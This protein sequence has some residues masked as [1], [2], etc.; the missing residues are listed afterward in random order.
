MRTRIIP[1]VLALTLVGLPAW[2]AEV[3]LNG[4]RITGAANL[5]LRNP[6]SVRI[7]ADGNIHIDAPGYRVQAAAAPP[8]AGA[9]SAPDVPRRTACTQRYFLVTDT[10]APGMVQYD[11]DVVV[12]GNAVRRIDDAEGQVIF[13][14]TEFLRPGQNTVALQAVKDLSRGRRGTTN[15]QVLRVL[16]G[17]G[18]D[19][20]GGHVTLLNQQIVFVVD[21]SQ[22]DPVSRQYSLSAR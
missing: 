11:V 2:A 8:A 5:T 13:E 20:G 14:V 22:V 17:E 12:N 1:L 6:A 21:A 16:V 15:G 9:T 4:E 7:D 3:F 18:R 19:D 10:N